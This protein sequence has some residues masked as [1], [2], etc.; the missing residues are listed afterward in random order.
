MACNRDSFTLL[1]FFYSYLGLEYE[2]GHLSP[3]HAEIKNEWRYASTTTYTARLNALGGW[4]N[5]GKKEN[6]KVLHML[7]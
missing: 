3:P 2:A 7:N 6:S 1:Y 4:H 5:K